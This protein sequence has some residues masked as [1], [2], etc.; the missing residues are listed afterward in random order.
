MQKIYKL[1]KATS[2]HHCNVPYRHLMLDH[3][4]HWE[5]FRL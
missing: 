3:A 2:L 4:L 1:L 5:I